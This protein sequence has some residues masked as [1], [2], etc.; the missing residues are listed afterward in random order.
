MQTSYLRTTCAGVKDASAVNAAQSLGDLGLDSLMSVE[1]KQTLERDYD[2][3]LP[4][5]EIRSLT[6]ASLDQMTH[7]SKQAHQAT[8]DEDLLY[9][10]SDLMPTEK[11]LSFGTDKPGTAV[12]VVPPI[13][14]TVVLLA[15]LASKL[16]CP[17]YGLQCIE[18]APLT[19]MDDLARYY[20]SLIK[21]YQPTGPYR[22]IGYSFGACV[23]LEMA[24]QLQKGGAGERV[25][26]LVL[27]DGSHTYVLSV[28][29]SYSDSLGSG[30]AN[31]V[32][33][34]MVCGFVDHIVQRLN[35]KVAMLA[36]LSVIF[37][38]VC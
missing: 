28:I 29:G 22:L 32:E 4:I 6:F 13:E 10:I 26:Q 34:A 25:E 35:T 5:K 14:G 2:L 30:D 19:S 33:T 36:S 24:L 38:P 15:P 31:E 23:A 21:Q 16:G 7:Q 17:V 9:N 1:I 37:T 8:V 18:E 11:V 3:N 20:I 27:L 12:F